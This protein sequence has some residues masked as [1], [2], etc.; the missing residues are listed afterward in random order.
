MFRSKRV[1]IKKLLRNA[2]IAAAVVAACKSWTKAFESQRSSSGHHKTLNENE[3]VAEKAKNKKWN[4][5]VYSTNI[6]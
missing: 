4:K 6:I 5:S 2:V 3:P 1:G